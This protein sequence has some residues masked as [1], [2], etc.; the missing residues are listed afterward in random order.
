MPLNRKRQERNF[1]FLSEK[2]MKRNVQMLFP[3]PVTSQNKLV[4]VSI[5]TSLPGPSNNSQEEPSS[6]FLNSVDEVDSDSSSCDGSTCHENDD[7]PIVYNN[8]EWSSVVTK[9]ETAIV[10]WS[11]EYPNVPDRAKSGLLQHL[12]LFFP[13][14]PLTA[15]TL[16][17]PKEPD[18]SNF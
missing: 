16:L 4:K 6:E 10:N 3:Y 1:S 17:H 15:K 11:Y 7:S 14:L 8:V 18:V 2:H 13:E 12:A 5:P 9:I